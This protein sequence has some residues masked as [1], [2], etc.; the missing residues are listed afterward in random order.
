MSYVG[1]QYNIYVLLWDDDINCD[2][3]IVY[4]SNLVIV[5]EMMDKHV[6]Y[7]G[8]TFCRK[9]TKILFI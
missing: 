1:V 3:K 2:I 4:I 9:S 8:E 5:S 7:N 6:P